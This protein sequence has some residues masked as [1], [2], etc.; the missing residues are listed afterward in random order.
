MRIW[1][2]RLQLPTHTW[3]RRQRDTSVSVKGVFMG[4]VTGESSGEEDDGYLEF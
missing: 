2:R 3:Y 4:G 1:Y